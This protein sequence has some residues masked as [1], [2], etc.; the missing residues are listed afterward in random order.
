MI[1][2]YRLVLG[3]IWLSQFLGLAA[4]AQ[5]TGE[6][7]LGMGPMLEALTSQGFTEIEITRLDGQVVV[8]AEG[9]GLTRQ[10]VF[11]ACDGQLVSDEIRDRSDDPVDPAPYRDTRLEG[12]G[13]DTDAENIASGQE[14]GNDGDRVTGDTTT[15]RDNNCDGGGDPKKDPRD[16]GDEESE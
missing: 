11:G 8:D 5:A 13:E 3:S 15:D 12:V 16:S 14:D 10:L 2:R 6:G 1:K 9:H 4:L 7:S